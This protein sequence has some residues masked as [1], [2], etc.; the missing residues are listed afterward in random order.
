MA[1]QGG[2]DIVEDGLVLHLDERDINSY[3]SGQYTKDLVTGQTYSGS[4]YTSADWANGV[5]QITISLW[6]KKT[7]NSTIYANNQIFAKWN[8][9]TSNCSFT[10]YHFHNF[11]GTSPNSEGL[12][13]WYANRG[14]SWGAISGGTHLTIGDTANIVLQYNNGGFMWHNGVRLGSRTSSGNLGSGSGGINTI[15]GSNNATTKLFS[16]TCHGR[17]LTDEEIRQNYNATKGRFGL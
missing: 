10:L 5:S 15:F 12:L 13:S 14:G 8:S 6:L 11:N 2:P 9:G 16:V 1:I 17:E 4:N 3:L 7:G